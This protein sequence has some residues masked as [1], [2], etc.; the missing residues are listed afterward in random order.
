MA[1][2]ITRDMTFYQVLEMNPEAAKVLEQFNLNCVGCLGATTES[3]AH[4]VRANGLD[5]DEI[6]AALNAIFEN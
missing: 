4:S 5:L 2:K 1:P 6:L 3:I